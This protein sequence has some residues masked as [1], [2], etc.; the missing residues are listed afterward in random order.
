MGGVWDKF[1]KLAAQLGHPRDGKIYGLR[2]EEFVE[3]E[4]G[5]GDVTQAG[6]NAF[7]GSNSFS[8]P[9]TSGSDAT[10]PDELVRLSQLGSVVTQATGTF[11]PVLKGSVSDPTTTSLLSTGWWTRVG[12]IAHVFIRVSWLGLSGGDGALEFDLP[13]IAGFEFN[14]DVVGTVSVGTIG[15]PSGCN[16][17][18]SDISG[19]KIVI[20]GSG[21]FLASRP[22]VGMD[23]MTASGLI[24]LQ[25]TAR[26]TPSEV[27]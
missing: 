9:P 24:E 10:N 15:Y 4:I 18:T 13:E 22:L 11:S 1:R 27:V 19:G 20:R 25:L 12:S 2:D 8:S 16:Y 21:D 23:N 7:T 6:D 5:E 17:L 3:V 26:L 14:D